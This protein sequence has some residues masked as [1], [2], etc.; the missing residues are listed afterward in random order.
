MRDKLEEFKHLLTNPEFEYYMHGTGRRGNDEQA[1]VV[2][3]IFENGLRTY[4]GR[5]YLTTEF[6]GDGDYMRQQ[7]NSIKNVMDD[8][9]HMGSKHIIIIRLPKKYL[10]LDSP[11]ELGIRDAAF[12]V[13]VDEGNSEPTKFINSKF[14]VGCYHSKTGDF[15][16]NPNFEQELKSDTEKDLMEK[17]T[18][19][20][21]EFLKSRTNFEPMHNRN[22]T[23][24]EFTKREGQEHVDENLTLDDT[25]RLFE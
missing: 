24:A 9:P 5:L 7:W 6:F 23:N 16:L 3:S 22:R 18:C 20:M 1:S 15:D 13:D 2:A 14:V 10:I 11:E 17:Y 12:Y 25:D 21:A 8:W 4:K 19:A